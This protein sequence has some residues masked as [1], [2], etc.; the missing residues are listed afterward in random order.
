M[1]MSFHAFSV[2]RIGE[3]HIRLSCSVQATGVLAGLL[4][5]LHYRAAIYNYR[6]V[7]I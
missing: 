7:M 3:L 2:W 5:Y 4:G 1:V 6:T